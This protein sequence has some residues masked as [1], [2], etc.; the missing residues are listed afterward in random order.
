MKNLEIAHERLHNQHLSSPGSKKPADVVR[1][2]G[3]V[4]AQDYYAFDEYLVSYKDRSAALADGYRKQGIRDSMLIG[5][6]IVI[7]GRVVGTWK[8]SLEKELVKI[9]LSAF[10]P[11]SKTERQAVGCAADRYGSFLGMKVVVLLN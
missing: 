9:T 2:L 8:R 11:L 1:W 10:S 7:G 5:S 3:A 6:V 4:Q